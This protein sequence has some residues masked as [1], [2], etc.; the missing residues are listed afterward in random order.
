MR[1][2]SIGQETRWN[3]L[4]LRSVAM[5]A[6]RSFKHQRNSPPAEESKGLLRLTTAG[7]VDDG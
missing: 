6:P 5:T 3:G 2:L 4:L 7:S 1:E